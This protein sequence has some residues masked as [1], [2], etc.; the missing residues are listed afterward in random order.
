MF[1]LAKIIMVCLDSMSATKGPIA[2]F[3]CLRTFVPWPSR[4]RHIVTGLK[5]LD[6]TLNLDDNL[7]VSSDRIDS[8]FSVLNICT[9]TDKCHKSYRYVHLFF[10]LQGVH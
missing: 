2:S 5:C 4:Y 9:H 8:D 10:Y 1:L 7:N 3:T 6:L